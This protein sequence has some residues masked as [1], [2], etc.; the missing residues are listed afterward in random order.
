MFHERQA[1][2]EHKPWVESELRNA[3]IPVIPWRYFADEDRRRLQEE[4]LS[5][6]ILVLRAN[7]S[8]GG[9][10]LGA[11]EWGHEIPS[12]LSG[13]SDGFLAAAP[14]L[15]PHIPLNASACVFRDGAITVHPPSLQLIG[16]EQCTRRRFGYCGNDFGAVRELDSQL[17][18]DLA[19]LIERT[20][21]WLHS[22][23]YVGAFGV[24]ALVYQGQV[25]LTEI[26]PRF[27]GSSALCARI[28]RAAGRPDIY[29][30]H[31]GAVLG[32]SSPPARALSE[33]ISDQ[34]RYAQ[35]VVHNQTA[36]TIY[37]D[38]GETKMLG[39]ESEIATNPDIH[40]VPDAIVF[41]AIAPRQ[42]TTDGRTLDPAVVSALED[43]S[44]LKL[45]TAA[46]TPE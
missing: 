41:R 17:L 20:G 43:A 18:C 27:Q 34:P 24:D 11:I 4:L 9:A 16:I 21:R 38:P 1:T 37:W 31:V 8:D 7:R 45:S 39:F 46:L 35:I 25:L 3:G 12:R 15:E 40:I 10:G 6:R 5:N 30:C 26:N 32:L 23:G 2:F 44:R 22:E 13:N 42:V 36:G 29:A 33:L 14:L 19:T 28:D